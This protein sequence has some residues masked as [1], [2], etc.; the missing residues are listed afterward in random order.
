MSYVSAYNYFTLY[1]QHFS[2]CIEKYIYNPYIVGEGGLHVE[3][4][5]AILEKSDTF[6]LC[7]LTAVKELIKKLTGAGNFTSEEAAANLMK[8]FSKL[9][10]ML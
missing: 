5:G 4:A 7:E 9:V 3:M 10:Y 1:K 6:N 8:A 2:Q